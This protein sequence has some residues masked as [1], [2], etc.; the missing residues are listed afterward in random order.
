MSHPYIPICRGQDCRLFYS[1]LVLPKLCPC[2]IHSYF[3]DRHLIGSIQEELEPTTQSNF[4]SL[5]EL[6]ELETRGL[7]GPN[8]VFF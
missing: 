3:L 4:L 7:E 8:A 5:V 1:V 6:I 2:P